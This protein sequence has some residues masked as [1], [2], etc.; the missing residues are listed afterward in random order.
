MTSKR[1]H[2]HGDLRA[3]LIRAGTELISEGGLD[4]L[5]IRKAAARAGVSHAAPAHHFP[6]LCD[7]RAAVAAD[8]YR[9][10]TQAM[11]SEMAKA[12]DQPRA[13]VLAAGHGY[14][15]FAT[16]TPAL[17]HLMF[18][19]P[20]YEHVSDELE[21]EAARSYDV[22][23]QISAPFA[24]GPAGEQGTEFLIWSLV[25]GYASLLIGQSK[26]ADLQANAIAM[27]DAIV[28][29]LPLRAPPL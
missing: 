22:L 9:R 21:R 18:G 11:L 15:T 5:S 10:F 25:H 17:F 28:P 1:P 13:Q 2:H 7:L 16:G 19:G 14:I 20:A 23:R 12:P 26:N 29:D 24:P 8:G 3:A 4:A 27:F 6:H